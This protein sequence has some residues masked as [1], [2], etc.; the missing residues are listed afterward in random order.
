MNIDCINNQSLAALYIL[1][2]ASSKSPS[3]YS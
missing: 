3:N 2:H 1:L